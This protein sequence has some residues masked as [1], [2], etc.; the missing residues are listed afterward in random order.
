[1]IDLCRAAGRVVKGD[2]EAVDEDEAVSLVHLA[3]GQFALDRLVKRLRVQEGRPLQHH[4]LGFVLRP[5]HRPLDL[6]EFVRWRQADVTMA[7]VDRPAG[8]AVWAELGACPL[9][10]TLLYGRVQFGP[11]P[12]RD[13]QH[14]RD[15]YQGKSFVGL[16]ASAAGLLSSGVRDGRVTEHHR[17]QQDE[18]D[19]FG[20]E[21]RQNR[22]RHFPIGAEMAHRVRRLVI[23][24][25]RS[26]LLNAPIGPRTFLLRGAS[27]QRFRCGLGSHRE[28]RHRGASDRLRRAFFRSHNV[29]EQPGRTLPHRRGFAFHGFQQDRHRLG[30]SSR[31][32][33][34]AASLTVKS[35]S[36]SVDQLFQ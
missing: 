32:C 2:V 19:D 11:G 16:F 26:M 15:Q 34:A 28:H 5:D 18:G 6:A 25:T 33:R 12:T 24:L 20:P 10:P 35:S 31:N 21:R 36:P 13:D 22:L 14:A 27:G 7:I 1:M 17:D 3:S 29:A 4:V 9:S 23:H 8:A 30:P